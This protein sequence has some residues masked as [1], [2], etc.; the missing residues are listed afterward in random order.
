M[1]KP[2]LIQKPGNIYHT[3]THTPVSK[4]VPS[5]V[6]ART[7]EVTGALFPH[8]SA[9]NIASWWQPLI[10]MGEATVEIQRRMG[11]KQSNRRPAHLR[12][13]PSR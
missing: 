5:N 6:D 2:E 1:P 3:P 4:R 11:R 13:T 9:D 8:Q 12:G 7:G 10:E